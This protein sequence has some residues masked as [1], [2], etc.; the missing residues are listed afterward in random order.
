MLAASVRE[1]GGVPIELGIARDERDHL[2]RL[3]ERGLS[4]DV[5]VLSGGVSAGILDLVPGV[6]ADLGVEQVF[7]KVRLKPGKPLWFGVLPA[8]AAPLARQRWCSACRAI[9]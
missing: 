6:L 4:S 5:L 7:H 8:A 1:G 9:R 3:V 2:A